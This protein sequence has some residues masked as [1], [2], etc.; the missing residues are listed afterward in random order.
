MEIKRYKQ[1]VKNNIKKDKFFHNYKVA[2]L[3]GG[4]FGAGCEMIF[5]ILK[6]IT[7]ISS[8]NI[9][10]YITLGVILISSFLTALGVFDNYISKY[11]SGLIV[12][13]TGFAHSVTSSAIDAKKEGL[14][15]GLGSN[16]FHLA[17]SVILY[18]VISSFI[19][20][21]IKVILYA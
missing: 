14:I 8:S 15:K 6:Q 18:S 12:P 7:N 10:S 9:K 1:I 20:V 19:L 11:R 2:F 17:G 4:L 3:S 5:Q 13:T 21:L 16:V